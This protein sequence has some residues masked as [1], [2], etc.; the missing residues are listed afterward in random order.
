MATAQGLLRAG[1]IASVPREAFREADAGVGA[2]GTP[3]DIAMAL[4]GA[5]E[6][7]A[8][9]T[10]GHYMHS[11]EWCAD[12]VNGALAKAGGKG[13]GNALARSFFARGHH[14]DPGGIK[15][16]DVLVSQGHVGLAEGPAQM[17]NGRMMVPMIAG[18][19]GRRSHGFAAVRETWESLGKYEARRADGTALAQAPHPAAGRRADRNLSAPNYAHGGGSSDHLLTIDL[20]DPG[21]AVKSTR[22]QRNGPLRVEMPNRWQTG[23]NPLIGT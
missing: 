20:R 11:G 12:F 21:G 23:R 18:N 8:A 5:G 1:Q 3:V 10:L 6:S 4:R 15:K 17:R 16:G 7:D 13:T 14:V 19:S 2:G 9:R 22:I